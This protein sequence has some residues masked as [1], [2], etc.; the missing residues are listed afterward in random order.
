MGAPDRGVLLT[1]AYDGRYF[2][3]FANQ[4]SQRTIEGELV[5]ALRVIDPSITTVRGASRT[6]A[7]VHAQDQRVAFDPEADLPPRGW[8]HALRPHLPE[9]IAI[10]RAAAVPRGFVPRFESLGKRYRYLLLRDVVPDPFFQGRAWRIEQLGREEGLARLCREAE[11][12]T[13]THDFKAFRS[14]DDPRTTT[15]RTLREISISEDASDPRILR[16]DIEGNAFMH[17][18]VRILVGTFVDVARGRLPEGAVA[19]A[20]AS[21]DRRDAGITAPAA[22]L[23]LQRVL[24]RDEGT[25]A[26][27]PDD[28]PDASEQDSQGDASR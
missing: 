26:W 13:G 3:G 12:A 22:G 10:R 17:N 11:A 27:P 20:I 21:G 19:R 1:V 16:I 5:G 4:P 25:G 8:A 6:D 18:M 15:V 14:S 9:E 28:A 23:Y 2:A 7:G 24:L